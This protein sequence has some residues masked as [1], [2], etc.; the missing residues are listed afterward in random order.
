MTPDDEEVIM[1]PPEDWVI[2]VPRQ[3][4]FNTGTPVEPESDWILTQ[5][6]WHDEGIWDDDAVWQD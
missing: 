4:P 1:V 2:P 6:F 5:G 3:A